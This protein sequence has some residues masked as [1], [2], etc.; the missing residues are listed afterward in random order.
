[1]ITTLDMTQEAC[2]TKPEQEPT[3]IGNYGYDGCWGA[4]G[5]LEAVVEVDRI[6]ANP[7]NRVD[8]S[9]LD[10][11]AVGDRKLGSWAGPLFSDVEFK[12]AGWFGKKYYHYSLSYWTGCSNAGP[13]TPTAAAAVAKMGFHQE[14]G[15]Q[16]L[17]D[18]NYQIRDWVPSVSD[19]GAVREGYTPVH[20]AYISYTAQPS[21]VAVAFEDSDPARVKRRWNTILQF[22]RTYRFAE[23]EGF[24]GNFKHWPFSNYDRL[25]VNSNS[26]V[27]FIVD[28][29]GLKMPKFDGEHGGADQPPVYQIINS[30]YQFINYPTPV[31]I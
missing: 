18:Y 8:P 9:G 12:I 16:L 19:S 21:R 10:F 20:V 11:I 13:K 23:Q 25:G 15:V 4:S 7:I 27:R 5:T 26:F 24:A 17:V 2:R 3:S 6:V 31:Y 29:A 22:S 14:Q 1:M 30:E 28:A